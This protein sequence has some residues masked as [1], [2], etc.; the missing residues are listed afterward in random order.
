MNNYIYNILFESVVGLAVY[1]QQSLSEPK[2][3]LKVQQS[4]RVLI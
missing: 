1:T 3:N 2:N 4:V